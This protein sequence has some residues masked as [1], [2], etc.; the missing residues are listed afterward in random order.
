VIRAALVLIRRHGVSGWTLR[1]AARR[2]G[3][4]PG[5]PYQHFRDKQAVLAQIA[6][7]GFAKLRAELDAA[8]A[9]A[10]ADPLLELQAIGLGYFRFAFA[11]AEHFRVM[12][13]REPDKRAIAELDALARDSFMRT[14]QV[15]E[16]AQRAGVA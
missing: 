10:G 11:N 5:A 4:S 14:P 9:G 15:I 2:A 6:H 12:F 7:D 13:S 8:L 1:E 16:R 3:V